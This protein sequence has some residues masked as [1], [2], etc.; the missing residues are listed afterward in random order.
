MLWRGSGHN[1]RMPWKGLATL[2]RPLVPQGGA[3]PLWLHS[4]DQIELVREVLRN[5]SSAPTIHLLLY[6]TKGGAQQQVGYRR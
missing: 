3:P 4:E 6:L 5:G 2:S 1:G